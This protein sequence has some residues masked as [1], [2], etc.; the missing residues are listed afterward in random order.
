MRTKEQ[1]LSHKVLDS[2]I[3]LYLAKNDELHGYEL[4]CFKA[5]ENYAN[6]TL[7]VE[8]SDQYSKEPTKIIRIGLKSLKALV[9]EALIDK[10]WQPLCELELS[11]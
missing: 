2:L 3:R 4:V 9:I 11:K 6:T 5:Q 8:L 1:E 10:L 7:I